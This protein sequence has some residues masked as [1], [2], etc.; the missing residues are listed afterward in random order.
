MNP[1]C[2]NNNQQGLY[3]VAFG[4]WRRLL[5]AGWLFNKPQAV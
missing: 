5:F 1:S 3:T 2:F 4:V